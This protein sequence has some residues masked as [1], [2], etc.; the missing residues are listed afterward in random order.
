MLFKQGKVDEAYDLIRGVANKLPDNAEVQ[1][2]LAAVLAKKGD[3]DEAVKL[4]RRAVNGPLPPSVK[5][6]AQKLLDQLTK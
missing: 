2:H 1:Y 3:K 6:E 5:S 4:L